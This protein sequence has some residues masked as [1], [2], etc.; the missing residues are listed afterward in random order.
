MCLSLR[1]ATTNNTSG[2]YG[3]K[4]ACLRRGQQER[5][6]WSSSADVD[7]SNRVFSLDLYQSQSTTLVAHYQ[8]P[9]SPKKRPT[10][11]SGC[12]DPA[13]RVRFPWQGAK[14]LPQTGVMGGTTRGPRMK[15]WTSFPDLADGYVSD[16]TTRVDPSRPGLL[17]NYPTPKWISLVFPPT[18]CPLRKH[19]QMARGEPIEKASNTNL[20]DFR[21]SSEKDFDSR[22]TSRLSVPCSRELLVGR[23]RSRRGQP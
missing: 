13:F 9:G 2:C 3:C 4:L 23:C 19:A 18:D 8:P 22:S 6:R 1:S 10:R 15:M 7:K 16:L 5:G 21:S 20:D 17:R 14:L 12:W 11:D